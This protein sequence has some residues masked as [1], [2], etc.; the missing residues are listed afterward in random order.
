MRPKTPKKLVGKKSAKT[1]HAKDRERRTVLKRSIQ[2]YYSANVKTAT[3][4]ISALP[5]PVQ[6]KA[7]DF[8]QGRNV[9]HAVWG[10]MAQK[11]QTKRPA[12]ELIEVV[13]HRHPSLEVRRDTAR[14]IGMYSIGKQKTAALLLQKAFKREK[15]PDVRCGIAEG[16]ANIPSARSILKRISQEDP[17]SDVKARSAHL[18]ELAKPEE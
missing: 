11:P 6:A 17:N 12:L 5:Q 9:Y 14:A 8:F 16:L 2:R 1:P 3:K 13:L 4:L 10:L 15:N 18:L 7:K